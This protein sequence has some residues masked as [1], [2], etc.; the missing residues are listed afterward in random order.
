[1]MIE[2]R[3]PILI[4]A[5][6]E[7]RVVSRLADVLQRGVSQEAPHDQRAV[8]RRRCNPESRL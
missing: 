4:V 1:M 3:P 6:V 5:T 8:S 7:G 2:S